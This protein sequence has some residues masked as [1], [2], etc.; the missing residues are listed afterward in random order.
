LETENK[1]LYTKAYFKIRDLIM[2]NPD[3][4]VFVIRGGQGASKTVSILELIIQSLV[5]SPKEATILSS[6]L[7]KMKRTVMRDYKKI[8]KD[9]GVI[10]NDAEFNRS[11]SKHEYPN[12]SYLDFLGAD[13]TSV[14]DSGVTSCTLTRPIRW[15]STRPFSSLA[16]PV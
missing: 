4:R 1:Y 3:Q 10:N 15:I 8:C 2:S 6:E 16:G 13:V 7:S 5:S 14:K 9:W 12:D 11:D